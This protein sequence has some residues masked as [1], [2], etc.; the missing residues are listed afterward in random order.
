M[1]NETIVSGNRGRMVLCLQT[2]VSCQELVPNQ[3]GT[4][5]ER[6]RLGGD[7]VEGRRTRAGDEENKQHVP[8][9]LNMVLLQSPVRTGPED[10]VG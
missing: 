1:E 8:V 5:K 10:R 9:M 7:Y 4:V 2:P 3:V 6:K